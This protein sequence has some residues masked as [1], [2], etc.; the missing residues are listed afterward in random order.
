MSRGSAS[1]DII[2]KGTD[3]PLEAKAIVDDRLEP[4]SDRR[5]SFRVIDKDPSGLDGR[6]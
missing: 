4:K 5:S 1:P 2:T 6:R 3:R